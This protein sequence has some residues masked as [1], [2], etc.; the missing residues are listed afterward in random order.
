MR[1]ILGEL[2]CFLAVLPLATSW[3]NLSYLAF[4][5]TGISIAHGIGAA[6]PRPSCYGFVYACG[7]PGSGPRQL[8]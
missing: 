7:H 6:L 2:V 4:L 3:A 5:S 1:F 8:V